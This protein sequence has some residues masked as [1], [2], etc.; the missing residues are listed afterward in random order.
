LTVQQALAPVDRLGIDTAPFIYF[1]EN[2]PTYAPIIQSLF[3]EADA[4][5]IKL[6]TSV[7]TVTEVLTLP[8]RS[9]L[10][11]LA[12]QYRNYMLNSGL[13][14]SLQNIDLNIAETAAQLRAQYN[15]KTPD[16]FQ[17]ATAIEGKCTAF[18]TNDRALQKVLAIRVIVLEDM[19]V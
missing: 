9:G 6:I 3:L 8:Y 5:Q 10:L 17:L 14:L 4:R 1:I 11:S 15:L 18:L 19:T 16:A 13:P 12:Q 7:V 2:H